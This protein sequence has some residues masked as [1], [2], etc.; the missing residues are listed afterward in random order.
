[1][2]GSWSAANL[3]DGFIPAD[4]FP[5]WGGKADAAKLV[6]AGLWHPDEVDGEAGWRFHDWLIHQPDARTV[7]LKQEAESRA[8]SKGNH[9][10]WHTKRGVVDPEC[11]HCKASGTRSPTRSGPR[12]GNLI[13][14]ES[15]VP[16]LPVLKDQNPSASAAAE[17]RTAVDDEFAAWWQQYPLKKDKGHAAKA[18]RAARRKVSAEVLLEGLQRQL[19]DLQRRE[20]AKIP[21]AATWLNGERW[22]DEPNPD[23]G[24]PQLRLAPSGEPVIPFAPDDKRYGR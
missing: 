6:E 11:E 16:A 7:K 20:P 21:Y 10:R 1:M 19:P 9:L 15:P 17:R 5:R 13:A 8:G 14:P 18:Y 23:P 24:R 22:A 4:I 12:S 3:T 2:A